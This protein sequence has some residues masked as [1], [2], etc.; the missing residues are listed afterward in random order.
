MICYEVSTLTLIQPRHSAPYR[1]MLEL[2]QICQQFQL[3]ELLLSVQPH[4][5]TVAFFVAGELLSQPRPEGL[6]EIVCPKNGSER[7]NVALVY[8]PMP[9]VL[10]PS[11]KWPGSWD[12]GLFASPV[13][14]AF[15]S[16]STSVFSSK[17]CSLDW[18]MHP[19]A[20]SPPLHLWCWRLHSNA[21]S[22]L[23]MWAHTWLYRF[24]V[25]ALLQVQIKHR[26][27]WMLSS[28]PGSVGC[29]TLA[30]WTQQDTECSLSWSVVPSLTH[31]DPPASVFGPELPASTILHLKM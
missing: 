22:F 25:I 10:S 16:A 3:C 24:V 15:A 27:N 21:G 20:T 23:R 31:R 29:L 4:V 28:V 5:E 14:R 17:P 18:V 26:I 11:P 12:C 19:P 8:P 9:T 7:V 1:E 6:T 2:G 30:R 13:T